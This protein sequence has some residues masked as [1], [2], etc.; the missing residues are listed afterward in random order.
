MNIV[1]FQYLPDVLIIYATIMLL[2][3]YKYPNKMKSSI[4]LIILGFILKAIVYFNFTNS[5]E[6]IKKESIISN[7]IFQSK[8]EKV[9]KLKEFNY[10][11]EYENVSNS[12]TKDADK[13][14]N[15]VKKLNN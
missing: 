14:H 3:N 6:R 4:I 1:F 15:S 13:I 12:I 10:S 7:Q 8:M 11:K 5:D 9:K 2:I